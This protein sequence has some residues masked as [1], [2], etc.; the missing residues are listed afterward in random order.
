MK[1]NKFR[2]YDKINRNMI[3]PGKRVYMN[4]FG[5]I[6]FESTINGEIIEA[7]SS[8]YTVMGYV[9]KDRNDN[10][11]YENDVLKFCDYP[12]QFEV[13]WDNGQLRY[14]IKRIDIPN[15]SV[16]EL[17]TK[18]KLLLMIKEESE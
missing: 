3:Y 16:L 15:S 10:D 13:V 4:M 11:V 14:M 8:T 17:L 7:D 1:E 2:I 6:V 18:E 5:E 12:G 9:G